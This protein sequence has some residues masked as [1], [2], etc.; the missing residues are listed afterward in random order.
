MKTLTDTRVRNTR[1]G[2]RVRE[3]ADHSS[4]GLRLRI[5][6]MGRKTW[7]YRY[8]DRSDGRLVKVTVGHYPAMTL[9]DARTRWLELSRSGDPR[10]QVA[11]EKAQVAPAPAAPAIT[12]RELVRAYTRH[13]SKPGTPG[14]LR[15][16]KQAAR[17]LDRTLVARHGARPARDLTRGDVRE[18]LEFLCQRGK[19]VA[20]NRLLANIRVL[21]NWAILQDHVESNPCALLRATPEHPRDRTLSDVEL[22]TLLTQLPDTDLTR[23][24]QDLVTFILATGV[25]VSEACNATWSE[26]NLEQGEWR[27]P[28]ARCK[29]GR[30]HTVYLSDL[31][32]EILERQPQGGE[33]VWPHP[34]GDGAVRSNTLGHRLRGALPV[35][36]LEAFTLHDLRRSMASW[37]GNAEVDYRTIERVLN[38]T[39]PR[40]ERTYNTARYAEQVRAA[41][42]AWGRHLEGLTA[43]NVVTLRQA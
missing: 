7:F 18:L 39:L 14:F 6:P 23:Q 31:V 9:A 37:L 5:S 40:L 15:S 1:P 17:A 24:E 38:H 33:L 26:L 22:R 27:I 20:A 35:L 10:A 32:T 43:E 42:Q 11:A 19:P 34:S 28:A 13:V 16:W 36:G 12:I 2:T 30:G 8:R 29:N 3:L 41:W 25:R 21:F 4:P